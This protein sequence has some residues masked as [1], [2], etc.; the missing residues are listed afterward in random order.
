MTPENFVT[1]VRSAVVDQNV[2]IY[3]ELFEST[4]PDAASD[5]YW[6]RALT[7]YRSLN[8]TDRLVL[9]EIMRQATVDTVSN[10]FAILDGVSA[11]EGPREDF[12]LT[13]TSDRQKINGNLQDLF[14]EADERDRQ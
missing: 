10:I 13:T 6:K 8:E 5:P 14:L 3:K 9:F 2:A 7:L 12:A 1:Q 11:L 4:A